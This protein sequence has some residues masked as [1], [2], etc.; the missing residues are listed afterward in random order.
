MTCVAT[1]RHP[2]YYPLYLR[3]RKKRAVVDGVDQQPPRGG[4]NHKLWLRE[5]AFMTYASYEDF[6]NEFG[7]DDLPDD[8]EIRVVR[9]IDRAS[10]LADT[11]IRSNGINV[12][13]VDPVAIADVRGSVLDIAR[14][15]AWPDTDSENLR[16]RYEDALA[17]LEGVAT[18]KIHLVSQGQ[19]T[20]GSRL[21]NIRLFRA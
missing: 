1:L 7:D 20:T 21:T 10:R 16:K 11:Y 14:Y 6:R 2:H 15:N 4:I 18:G 19:T 12:P 8:A 3:K 13:L 9:A 17:F 5:S